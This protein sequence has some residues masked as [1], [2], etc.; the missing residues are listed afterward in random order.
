MPRQLGGPRLGRVIA[1]EARSARFPHTLRGRTRRRRDRVA[2]QPCLAHP[3]GVPEA[4]GDPRRVDGVASKLGIARRAASF[5]GRIERLA[6]SDEAGVVADG[7]GAARGQLPGFGHCRP[8]RH[9]L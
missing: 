6:K 2:H 8:R 9:P 7:K 4:S 5:A 3:A 1:G